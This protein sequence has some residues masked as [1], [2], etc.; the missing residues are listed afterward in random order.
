MG[1][2]WPD[3]VVAEYLKFVAIAEHPTTGDPERA[4]ARAG[5]E[6][7]K[8]KYPGIDAQA[9]TAA[10][11]QPAPF[12]WS[13][14]AAFGS[15]AWLAMQQLLESLAAEVNE[16]GA[17]GDIENA[18]DR[19]ECST[20]VTKRGRVQVVLE[21]SPSATDEIIAACGPEDQRWD[22][23]GRRFAALAEAAFH[24]AFEAG[25]E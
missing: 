22:I 20:N 1:A 8:K 7:R 2:V 10:K 24:K 17:I 6:R 5:I 25:E 13:A 18:V 14:V 19:V 16:A 4:A 15:A 3:D 23:A 11:A 21:F 12:D 9:R